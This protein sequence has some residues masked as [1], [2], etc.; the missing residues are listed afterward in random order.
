MNVLTKKEF[1]IKQLNSLLVNLEKLY[2]HESLSSSFLF[3]PDYIIVADIMDKVEKNDTIDKDTLKQLNFIHR[4]ALVRQKN[5]KSTGN[6][7]EYDEWIEWVVKDTLISDGVKVAV[8]FHRSNALKDTGDFYTT[9][10]SID[11]VEQI[12]NK[13]SIK[14]K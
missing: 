12:R 7:L 3:A 4:K 2:A 5:I 1:I 14:K 13:H 8:A 10:E 9:H 6:I 11:I